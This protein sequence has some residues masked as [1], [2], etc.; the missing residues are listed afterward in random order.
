MPSSAGLIRFSHACVCACVEHTTKAERRSMQCTLSLYLMTGCRPI[1][2][3]VVQPFIRV[4]LLAYTG[5]YNMDGVVRQATMPQY[6]DMSGA[7]VADC[8]RYRG[9]T[10]LICTLAPLCSPGRLPS[11]C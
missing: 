9:S 11:L 3:T 1:G 5:T 10:K 4:S 7:V 6:F 8:C 2:L